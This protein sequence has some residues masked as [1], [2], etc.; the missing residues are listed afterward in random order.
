VD[1]HVEAADAPLKSRGTLRLARECAFT[2]SVSV[3]GDAFFL[4]DCLEGITHAEIVQERIAAPVAV[5]NGPTHAAVT[6]AIS[7]RAGFDGERGRDG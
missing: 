1:G 5:G 4:R 2:V 6:G 3:V 7:K